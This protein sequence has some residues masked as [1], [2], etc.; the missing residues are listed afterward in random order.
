MPDDQEPFLLPGDGWAT[1]PEDTG[2]SPN[3]QFFRGLFASW[4]RGHRDLNP[5]RPF[6]LREICPGAAGYMADAG[7]FSTRDLRYLSERFGFEA[8]V[9]AAFY[10]RF[11]AL[12]EVAPWVLPVIEI[13]VARIRSGMK[14]GRAGAR[15]PHPKLPRV[16]SKLPLAKLRLDAIA[17]A[18]A[19]MTEFI[20]DPKVAT[21]LWVGAFC[22]YAIDH[23]QRLRETVPEA[24]FSTRVAIFLGDR[25]PDDLF[26]PL[27]DAA[28]DTGDWSGVAN[29]L[30]TLIASHVEAGTRV[31]DDLQGNVVLAIS[32]AAQMLDELSDR[33]RL[34]AVSAL[35]RI[36]CDAADTRALP[37]RP[38]VVDLLA[39][40]DLGIDPSA[41]TPEQIV[42]LED[43]RFRSMGEELR[44]ALEALPALEARADALTQQIEEATRARRFGELA[45]LASQASEIDEKI[46]TVASLRGRLARSVAGALRGE[47]TAATGGEGTDDPVDVRDPVPCTDASSV[48]RAP[49]AGADDGPDARIAVDRAQER[50]PVPEVEPAAGASSAEVLAKAAKAARSARAPLAAPRRAERWHVEAEGEA[51]PVGVGPVRFDDDLRPPPLD[52]AILVELIGAGYVGI[53]G[54]VATAIEDVGS[55]WP[56]S[57]ASLRVAAASRAPHDDYGSDGQ[58]FAALAGQAIAE[59]RSDLGST[60]LL[61]SLLRPTLLQ[62]SFDLRSAMPDLAR[63]PLGPTLRGVA[64]TIASLP[65]DFPPA[66]DDLASMAG[67]K[68]APQKERLAEQFGDWITASAA[69]TSPWH[70]ATTLL[71]HL[72]GEGG[73]FGLAYEAIV[74]GDPGAIDVAREALMSTSSNSDIEALGAE[75]ARARGVTA[76]LY[77]RSI[78][79]IEDQLGG[80]RDI[81]RAWVTTIEQERGRRDQSGGRLK[82]I[83]GTLRAQMSEVR[84]VLLDQA[85]ADSLEGVVAAY[86]AERATEAI[87]TL[88]GA[89]APMFCMVDAALS[90]DRDVLPASARRSIEE[91]ERF[92]AALA[93][94]LDAA[95]LPT[96]REAFERALRD[97]AFE[98][99]ARLRERHDLTPDRDPAGEMAEFAEAAITSLKPRERRLK[100]LDRVDLSHREEITRWMGW[101][102]GAL[103]RLEDARD[104]QALEDLDDIPLGVERLDG[105]LGGVEAKVRED[106]AGRINK[107]RSAGNDADA[108]ALL[109]SLG[110]LSLEAA[111][112]RIAELR[113]GRSAAAFEADLEGIIAEF[114]PAFIEFASGPDWPASLD[115]FRTALEGG[116]LA[117]DEGR[118]GAALEFIATYG[119]LCQRFGKGQPAL[120]VVKELLDEIGFEDIYLNGVRALGRSGSWQ[121]GM[122]ATIRSD[123][124]FLP[125]IFGS[126]ATGGY[127]LFLVGPDALPEAIQK[128]VDPQIPSILIFSS[129]VN[130]TRRHEVAER[131]RAAAAPALLIDE[132]LVVF[133]AIRRDTR[134][135]TIFECG[136]PYGRTEA[137]TTDAGQ[138]PP[139]MFFGRKDEIRA[140]MSRSADGCL[141]YGGRQLG[142][143]ALLWHVSLT[144]HAPH[145]QRIVIRRE[146]KSLGSSQKTLEFWSILGDMLTPDGVVRAS[147]RT[148]DDVSRDVRSWLVQHPHGQIVCLFDEADNFMTQDTKDDYPQIS[149]IK[150]MMES[151]GRAFKVV[152]AGLHNVQRMHRQPNSPLA[153]LGEPICIGPLNRT[154]DDKRAAHDLVMA[155]MRAA[156][157][158]LEAV[159]DVEEILAWANYYPSLIQEFSKGLLSTLHGAGSGK[160]YCLDANGP[161][162]T[163]PRSELFDHAGFGR[164]EAR[165]REKFQLTLELDPRYALVA[166]TIG[167]LSAEGF[168]HEALSSGFR[169]ED[170]RVHAENYWMQS[171]ERPSQAAFDALLD[172]LFDLGVLG[173][174]PVS[175]TQRF[176]Y[177]LRTQQVAAMLGSRQDIE[178][179]LLSLE[180]RD[181]VV[182]YDRTV[183][184]RR[185]APENADIS[186]ASRE[187]PY[188]P[189]TDFQLEQLFSATH[190]PVRL[191]CGLGLLGL[192]KVPVALRQLIRNGQLPGEG[193]ADLDIREARDRQSLAKMVREKRDSSQLVVLRMPTAKD[194]AASEIEWLEKQPAVLDGL[195]RPI[196]L[197]DASERGLRSQAIR[198]EAQAV[199]LSPWGGEMLRVHLSNLEEPGL[200]YGELRERVLRRTG[201]IPGEVI[202]L[203]GELMSGRDREDVFGSWKPLTDLPRRMLSDPMISALLL[204]ED[205]Q[206]AGTYDAMN[207]LILGETGSDLETHGPDL[208]AAG[209]I[210]AWR[211]N[212]KSIRRSALGEVIATA[213]E[214]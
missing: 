209:L 78:R 32:S 178:H 4:T 85:D 72:V 34:E 170:L 195:I 94:I 154:E 1:M 63:G 29:H 83:V 204:V 189:L 109:K 52:P 24:E 21:D 60:L 157:F 211:P 205:T 128:A 133:A 177:C 151:T 31:S 148:A 118:R 55:A 17:D 36:A 114:T 169:S 160:A 18:E 123:D 44:S 207:E 100:L 28:Q 38:E 186:V 57:A 110:D 37:P 142:K 138:V 12:V 64:D 86:V 190:A 174:I 96:A 132:A 3:E 203:V 130:C 9:P 145:E 155:P 134:A 183:H 35:M 184:R 129:V 13:E 137:Y 5:L 126:Q 120:S 182:A 11:L 201:G 139:E 127:A 46:A 200:D 212:G 89:D 187:T 196:V 185:Y 82:S 164:I 8:C 81:L 214:G 58:R 208:R 122:R 14:S 65:H 2:R 77:P 90:A 70:F 15:A 49:D 62:Q 176:T 105:L 136:L 51:G 141:V 69:R 50:R 97:G 193:I 206:D 158:R 7:H 181:P 180:E 45:G 30:E 150:E 93:G 76:S 71:R 144:R 88:R 33:S 92:L 168:E 87:E 124:W 161:L 140:I 101:C 39:G 156:G 125:P 210:S 6:P 202:R 173:R 80:G 42:R 40:L 121:M 117:T 79:Y 25:P 53:A 99:A 41:L 102:E 135:R 197:L 166:Y 167:L 149:R 198:R 66:A 27:Y 108:D 175:G 199:F 103:A 54:D 147:S 153:H 116:P 188:S 165:V 119:D 67:T 146:V 104:G 47:K 75:L 192:S 91:P 26:E 73:P 152:F 43:D 107:Y 19:R 163:I 95:G 22:E 48:A 112:A 131:L 191:I 179:A 68:R 16:I 106:Q 159:E 113:D 172:E 10:D 59:E 213:I 115:D 98:V 162:W 20:L 61:G 143:S 194:E 84:S 74:S 111:E 56:I 23:Y 171:S